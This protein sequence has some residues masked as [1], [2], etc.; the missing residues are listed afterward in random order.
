M[1]YCATNQ[2]F[3]Y[4]SV[5]DYQMVFSHKRGHAVTQLIEALR[6]K[7]VRFFIG[8]ILPVA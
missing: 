1:Q 7:R 4:R 3:L 8:I 2:D 6:Y 5:L